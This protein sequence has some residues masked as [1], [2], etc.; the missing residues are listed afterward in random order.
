MDSELTCE[1][2][3]RVQLILSAKSS[4]PRRPAPKLAGLSREERQRRFTNALDNATREVFEV[5][6]GTSLG[7]SEEATLPRVADYAAMIGLAGDLCGVLSF[8]CSLDSAV[9]ITGR[10]LGTDERASE[11]CIRDA[12][13]E[14]CN[15]IA[16]SF[17]A[18]LS[19][20]AEQCMLSVPT[21]VSGN[22]YQ[23]Y[24][25]VDGLRIQVAKNFEGS[26]IWMTVDLHNS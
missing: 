6:V 21:V 23:L 18:Q 17:K 25:L 9:Q 4:G 2:P 14:T 15:M 13:G 11:E 26:L 7:A 22:D 19:D 5:M 3:K 20:I 1:S 10:L 8:R 16:G 12:L 24:A